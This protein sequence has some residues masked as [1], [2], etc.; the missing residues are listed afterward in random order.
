MLGE[1]ATTEIAR[2][3]DAQGF[4]RNREVAR[5]G[6]EVAG[7]ARRQ[8]ESKSGRKVVS[9]GNYLPGPKR[10]VLPAASTPP[11]GRNEEQVKRVAGE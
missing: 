11:E 6:G 3:R 2:N 5:E 8:L 4:D 10:K 1:A 7:T 9:R